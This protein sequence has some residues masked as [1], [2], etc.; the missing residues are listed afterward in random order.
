[1]VLVDKVKR[2][3]TK[4][5]CFDSSLMSKFIKFSQQTSSWFKE[6]KTGSLEKHWAIG[7]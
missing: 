3:W 5:S 1:M 7:T 2:A 4:E 6:T